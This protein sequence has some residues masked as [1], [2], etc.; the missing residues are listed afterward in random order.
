[1]ARR[2]CVCVFIKPF[3]FLSFEALMQRLI[4]LQVV[5]FFF[6]CCSPRVLPT[7][8]D[9]L[10]RLPQR[11]S[12]AATPLT[13]TQ[14]GR[15]SRHADCPEAFASKHSRFVQVRPIFGEHS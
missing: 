4:H 5:F 10:R 8:I 2:D 3:F 12:R 1:M 14:N 7:R 6:F 15:R 11:A 13:H 9:S